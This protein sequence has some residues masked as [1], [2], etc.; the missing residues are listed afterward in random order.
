MVV[1]SV[2]TS[3]MHPAGSRTGASNSMERYA[4]VNYPCLKTMGLYSA[5]LLHGSRSKGMN[6]AT[7]RRFL[8]QRSNFESLQ[9]YSPAVAAVL[10]LN[11]SN[12][13]HSIFHFRL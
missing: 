1:R 13:I 9:T 4:V 10:C 8:L 2:F 12:P 7:H 6:V 11:P 5:P 3:M